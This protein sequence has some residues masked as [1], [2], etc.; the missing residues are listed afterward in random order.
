MKV[1]GCKYEI[2]HRPYESLVACGP[3]M[4]DYDV[5]AIAKHLRTTKEKRTG[6]ET[7]EVEIPVLQ[8][9][10]FSV[11]LEKVDD[12]PRAVVTRLE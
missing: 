3:S 12:E 2:Y 10:K 9:K 5:V 6:G 8:M 7:I 11:R 1:A 4:S